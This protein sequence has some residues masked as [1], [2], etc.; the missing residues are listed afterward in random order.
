MGGAKRVEHNFNHPIVIKIETI[1]YSPSQQT[2]MTRARTW[3][4]GIGAIITATIALNPNTYVRI[5]QYIDSKELRKQAIA[6]T[7]EIPAEIDLAVSEQFRSTVADALEHYTT[8]KQSIILKTAI[9]CPPCKALEKELRSN[10]TYRI[11]SVIE[12]NTDE[13]RD[14]FR[15]QFALRG[16]FIPRAYPSITR[17]QHGQPQNFTGYN[18]GRRIMYDVDRGEHALENIVEKK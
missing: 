15:R 8:N 10:P 9:W 11:D 14:Y 3:A 7:Q 2:D 4:L 17:K 6:L 18:A 16:V 1:K 13:E 12:A 5:E